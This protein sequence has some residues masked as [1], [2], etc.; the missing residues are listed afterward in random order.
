MNYAS[1]AEKK[2]W[3]Y[4]R[5]GTK[6]R[7][8]HRFN[9][10]KDANAGRFRDPYSKITTVKECPSDFIVTDKGQ[11]FFAEVKTTIDRMGVKKNLFEQQSKER[12]LI[13][14]AGGKYYYFIYSI[15]FGSW[16]KVPAQVIV[17]KPNRSWFELLA[18]KIDYLEPIY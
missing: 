4:F 18:Y 5:D 8:I 1:L 15:T 11:M 2:V 16:Y 10:T 14:S 17:E 9:D 6:T 13:L 7:T 3:S 12:T